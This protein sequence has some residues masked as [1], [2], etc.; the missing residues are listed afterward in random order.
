MIK[1]DALGI[2]VRPRFWAAKLIYD[3]SFAI[4]LRDTAWQED[5]LSS[6]EPK[7]GDRTLLFGP[8]SSSSAIL[9]ALHNPNATFVVVDPSSK[10]A[11]WTRLT[12]VRKRLE[13]VTVMH[14]SRAHQLPVNAGSFDAVICMLAL[15]DSPPDE[16]L[17]LIREMTRVLRHA[18]TLRLVDFD[19]PETPGERRIL[20]LGRRVSGTLAV[21]SHLDGS[22][23]GVLAKVGV[24]GA[25][26]EFSHSVGV[27]RISMVKARKR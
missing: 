8:G 23:I 15:H 1:F 7:G 6:L 13:N 22:W 20:E 18:G 4:L 11:E 26:R 24:A 14:V 3:L 27:G 21:A 10:A 25:R 16:K 9:L 2:L 17:G 5:L 12:A 19:K